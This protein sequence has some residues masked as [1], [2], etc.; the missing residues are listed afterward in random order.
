MGRP[1]LPEE[2]KKV[3][4]TYKLAPG[5]IT[6]IDDRAKALGIPKTRYLEKLVDLDKTIIQEETDEES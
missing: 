2:E 4:K 3:R 6:W 1:K 5:V